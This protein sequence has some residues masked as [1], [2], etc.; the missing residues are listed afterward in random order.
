M[1]NLVLFTFVLTFFY[2]QFIYARVYK[3]VSVGE[4][5]SVVTVASYKGKTFFELM[6]EQIY[7]ALNHESQFMQKSTHLDGIKMGEGV[8]VLLTADVTTFHV[9]YKADTEDKVERSGRSFGVIGHE[10]VKLYV[11]DASYM[12]YL[13]SLE[14]LFHHYNDDEINLFYKAILNILVYC[15]VSLVDQLD[16]EG[17]KVAADFIAIYIAEQYRRLTATKGKSLGRKHRWDDALVQVTFL[18]AFHSGQLENTMFYEGVFSETVYPQNAC[19]Y[20]NYSATE[21]RENTQK[22]PSHLYDYWQ[23]STRSECPGRSGVNLTRRD[24]EKMGKEIT[25]FLVVEQE[26]EFKGKNFFKTATDLILNGKLK[27]SAELLDFLMKSRLRAHDITVSLKW[28][29]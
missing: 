24:F 17:K 5:R 11:A 19:L 6:K 16:L 8:E 10:Q 2:S 1:K 26:L 29:R 9:K 25:H 20:R 12:H 15:D 23:F 21:L 27:D 14:K 3:N 18:A 28:S 7:P 13:R 22:R 4:Y